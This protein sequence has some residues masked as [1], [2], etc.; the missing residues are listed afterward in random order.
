MEA[1]R[2]VFIPGLSY[3][4]EMWEGVREKISIPSKAFDIPEYGSKYKDTV[5]N[6]DTYPYCLRDILRKE[7]INP[8]Y[9]LVGH[10]L[11]GHI[12]IKYALEYPDEV[13]GLALVSTPLR[14]S[15]SKIPTAYQ[16]AISAAL[17]PRFYGIV[18]KI[19]DLQSRPF[20]SLKKMIESLGYVNPELLSDSHFHSVIL[21]LSDLFKHDFRNDVLKVDQKVLVVYGDRDIPLIKVSDSK[22]FNSFGGGI[23]KVLKGCKHDIPT[24]HPEK[25]ANLINNFLVSE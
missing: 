18:T 20:K 3:K 17:N 13:G 15:N 23:V 9:L 21:C 14:G 1:L 16:L 19:K 11:G 5:L 4:A 10:S 6:F 25:L 2:G 7:K 12:A 24:T 8:P 22:L